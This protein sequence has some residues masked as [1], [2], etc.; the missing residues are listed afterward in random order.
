M[1]IQQER[2]SLYFY[3]FDSLTIANDTNHVFGNYCGVE[4]GRT[5]LVT[6][7]FA[8]LTFQTDPAV[9]RTGFLLVFNPVPIGE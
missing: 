1:K 2:N 4:T 7:R 6:G 8:V 3:R 9:T 5:L